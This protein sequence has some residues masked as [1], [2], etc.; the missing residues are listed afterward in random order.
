MRQSVYLALIGA[1]AAIRISQTGPAPATPTCTWSAADGFTSTACTNGT[2]VC[3]S[4][5]EKAANAASTGKKS[6]DPAAVAAPA[7]TLAQGTCTWTSGSGFSSGTCTNGTD[8]CGSQAEKDANRDATGSKRSCDHTKALADTVTCTWSAA[9]GFT[10]GTCTNGTGQCGS[11][12]EKTANA[13]STGKKS[14][15]PNWQPPASTLA[16]GTCTWTSGSGFS[17]GT[18]TNGTDKCGSQ[19][20]KDANRDATGSKRSC[21]HTK[22]L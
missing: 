6:C 7:P 16:Q 21:D 2:G 17:S 8:K 18:C 14:C 10:S 9:S 3:G 4:D 11:E 12:A 1:T 22:A 13:A 20:E 15:D 5:A 19:A